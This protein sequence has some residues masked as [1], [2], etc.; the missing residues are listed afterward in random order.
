MDENYPERAATYRVS[1]SFIICLKMKN[2]KIVYPNPEGLNNNSLGEN[3]YNDVFLGLVKCDLPKD[4]YGNTPQMKSWEQ[5]VS[6]ALEIWK[7]ENNINRGFE[8]I[9][10]IR[11]DIFRVLTGS[12]VAIP[13]PSAAY[14]NMLDT[15]NTLYVERLMKVIYEDIA[16]VNKQEINNFN[17][18][19]IIAE[20]FNLAPFFSTLTGALDYKNEQLLLD[21]QEIPGSLNTVFRYIG[22]WP[23]IGTDD[24]E[25]VKELYT[26]LYCAKHLSFGSIE[27][28][29][30]F[31]DRLK[32]IDEKQYPYFLLKQDLNVLKVG[33]D[34]DKVGYSATIY[35]N[36]KSIL[37]GRDSLNEIVQDPLSTDLDKKDA[38]YAIEELRRNK[39]QASYD[40]LKNGNASIYDYFTA[41]QGVYFDLRKVHIGYIAASEMSDEKNVEFTKILDDYSTLLDTIKS[42]NIESGSLFQMNICAGTIATV[43]NKKIAE[44]NK[45]HPQSISCVASLTPSEVSLF[46]V[47]NDLVVSDLKANNLKDI[48]ISFGDFSS[49]LI[50]DPKNISDLKN[51]MPLVTILKK[52]VMKSIPLFQF[53]IDRWKQ[54]VTALDNFFVIRNQRQFQEASIFS[55]L[56]KPS[57]NGL[58]SHNKSN[59][60]Y[61]PSQRPYR[62][63]GQSI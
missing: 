15:L 30:E 49:F 38:A 44:I 21:E 37:D 13:K 27:E 5:S 42:K 7:R 50:N 28:S 2:G 51:R 45:K 16:D 24:I 35:E 55:G 19:T 39:V 41:K 12:T 54:K 9:N 62:K 47:L 3:K 40:R 58:P 25:R 8:Y 63:S 6:K 32:N 18:I 33:I 11:P 22:Q 56:A 31:F 46:S 29:A 1:S 20:G 36:L 52:E 48:L 26:Q 61:S 17:D 10:P 43:F 60:P 14:F 59:L 57:N 23:E 4:L 34:N 53:A